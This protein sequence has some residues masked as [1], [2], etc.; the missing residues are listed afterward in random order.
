MLIEHSPLAFNKSPAKHPVTPSL[1]SFAFQAF[2]LPDD[3]F[4]TTMQWAPVVQPAKRS[5]A[6]TYAVG[7]SD[8]AL[9]CQ[10]G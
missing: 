5:Q 4:P 9:Q 2:V 10:A 8:G 3:V 1:H 6:E 7:S